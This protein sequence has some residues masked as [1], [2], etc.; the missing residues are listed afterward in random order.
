M[1]FAHCPACNMI[2]QLPQ[3]IK[4]RELINCPH[5]NS[6]L[7]LASQYPPTLDWAEDPLVHPSRRGMKRLF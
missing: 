6:M 2:I 3:K 4:V 5:C 1:K 7:E